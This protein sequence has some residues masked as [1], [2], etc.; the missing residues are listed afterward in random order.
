MARKKK[1]EEHENHERWLV[2]YADFITL[3]FA[4]F[5]ALYAMSSANQAKFK[6]ASHSLSVAFNTFPSAASTM[7]QEVPFFV[8]TR[9][10]YEAMDFKE[11]NPSRYQRVQAALKDLEKGKKLTLIF[12]YQR[13]TIR[14]SEGMIFEPASD[15]I[16][17]G[18]TKVIDE[19]A[20][21]LKELPG[22]IRVEGHTD[23]VPVSSGKFPSNWDISTARALKILKYLIDDAGFEPRRLAAIGYGEY[24][25]IAS[26]DTPEGRAK[27]RRVDILIYDGSDSES[28]VN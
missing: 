13:I 8:E 4:F 27:N 6:A 12:D 28:D 11:T 17:E 19:I 14:I 2:S 26:N 23:N 25:P 9:R 1:H 22:N 20:A 16:V 21:A 24:R 3:L 18:G 15:E 7:V 5:T 10:P